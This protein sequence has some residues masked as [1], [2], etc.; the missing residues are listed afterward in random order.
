MTRTEFQTLITQIR[1]DQDNLLSSKGDDYTQQSDDVLHNFKVVAEQ[2]GKT[3]LEVWAVYAAK[4]WLAIMSFVKNGAVKSEPIEG[5]FRD[6][7]N[8]LL[9]GEGLLSKP[10]QAAP[11]CSVCRALMEAGESFVCNV[12]VAG[13]WCGKKALW[14]CDKDDCGQGRCNAHEQ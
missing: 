5:R 8:Y 2:T 7:G 6:L 11:T 4:H 10:P 9:L 13:E 3:P 12:I 14:Q 1:A